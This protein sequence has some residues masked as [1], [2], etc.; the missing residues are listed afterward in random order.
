M[1][2][3]FHLANTI[4]AIQTTSINLEKHNLKIN[5]VERKYYLTEENTIYCHK[6]KRKY[7]NR[8]PLLSFLLCL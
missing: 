1:D 3:F 7:E 5:L 4:I 8:K 2:S 6:K